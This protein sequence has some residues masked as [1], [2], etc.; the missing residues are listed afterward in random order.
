ML[1]SAALSFASL[2]VPT[3]HHDVLRRVAF[4]YAAPKRFKITSQQ[5]EVY[6]DGKELTVFAKAMRRYTVNPLKKDVARQVKKYFGS[7]GMTFGIGEL[8]LGDDPRK[9]IAKNFKDL[10]VAG[11]EDME[12]DRCL[13][14]DGLMKKSR[15]G[16][17]GGE[18]SDIP[19]S[20]W[21]RTSDHLIRRIEIDMAESMKERAKEEEGMQ[22]FAMIEDLKMVLDVRDLKVNQEI[23][24]DIFAFKPPSGV[25]K[26]DRFYSEGI[27]QP[28]TAVQFEMSGKKAP[29]FELQTT[30]G[31]WL[32]ADMLQDKVIVMQFLS[33]G[34]PG[35]TGTIKAL[36][37]V[38]QDY[39]D[40]AA[41]FLCV[42]PSSDADKLMSKLRD[43]DIDL[44]VLLDPD[45]DLTGKYFDE[46]WAGGIVLVSKE[47]IVQGKYPR[48]LSDDTKKSL[49][50][51]I[52]TLL[53]GESLSG[54]KAMTEEQIQ[55]M[56]SQRGARFYGEVADA[57]NEE[58]LQEAWSVRASGGGGYRVSRGGG[59]RGA[60]EGL[61]I[62][63]EDGVIRITHDGQIA[64]EIPL[65]KP[66]TD[67]SVRE[68]FLIGRIGSRTGVVHLTTVPGDQERYAW[69]PPKAALFTAYDGAGRERW[70]IEVEVKDQQPPQQMAMGN[71]DGRRGDELV[72]FHQGAIWV[73]DS[74]GEVIVRKPSPGRPRWLRVEDR[75]GDKRAEIYIRTNTKLFRFDYRPKR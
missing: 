7:M 44:T 28:D 61:W 17:F 12:G 56:E 20:I 10:D 39:R 62:R 59:A 5:H 53:K 27:Q 47:G 34:V 23:E 15:F 50:T 58:H 45:R 29:D 4:A 71:I 43:D 48:F 74:R 42:Y 2:H 6:S 33:A 30:D 73:V 55:E 16:P 67:V 41:E 31:R 38:Q 37:E 49:R 9:P 66:S 51:D 25:K 26:V 18:Q 64:E 13:R 21:L 1:A 60:G 40:K 46:Q 14:L 35:T 19:V 3:A 52:D 65:P 57:L 70:Q 69:R 22:F 36:Y 54:G 75:D 8:V 68:G 24:K 72:F 11:Y 32:T 63:S